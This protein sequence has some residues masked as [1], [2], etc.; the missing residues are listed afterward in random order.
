MIKSKLYRNFEMSSSTGRGRHPSRAPLTRSRPIATKCTFYT[1]PQTLLLDPPHRIPKL[2]RSSP[3][4]LLYP[5]PEILPG[6]R[7]PPGESPAERVQK[8]LERASGQFR[9]PKR[10]VEEGGQGGSRGEDPGASGA[11]FETI[12]GSEEGWSRRVSS[13]PGGT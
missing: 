1:V 6:R 10:G 9:G 11:S 5:L 12:Y 8:L 7:R 4:K 3:W 13:V 2:S